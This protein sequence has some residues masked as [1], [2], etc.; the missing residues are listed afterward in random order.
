MA[1]LSLTRASARGEHARAR[2][3]GQQC[4]WCGSI[5]GGLRPHWSGPFRGQG[6]VRHCLEIRNAATRCSFRLQ[7]SP[8]IASEEEIVASSRGAR[9]RASSRR[10]GRRRPLRSAPRP[11]DEIGGWP[12]PRLGCRLVHLSFGSGDGRTESVAD[13]P[14]PVGGC[15]SAPVDRETPSPESAYSGHRLLPRPRRAREH[16]DARVFWENDPP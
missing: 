4:L 7:F 12:C 1:D 15:T 8:P 6:Q 16:G 11:E 13:D 3:R 5:E 9:G 2:G 10:W 14:A